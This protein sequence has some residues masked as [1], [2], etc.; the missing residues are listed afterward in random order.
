MRGKKG[1]ARPS[2]YFS[3]AQMTIRKDYNPFVPG[4]VKA[5]NK[6]T[7]SLNPRPL[8]CQC[9]SSPP[10]SVGRAHRNV[11]EKANVSVQ[12]SLPPY[13][14]PVPPVCP[15]CDNATSKQ[16]RRAPGASPSQPL[17]SNSGSSWGGCTWVTRRALEGECSQQV[18]VASHQGPAQGRGCRGQS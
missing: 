10:G 3:L 4:P 9:Y 14:S 2:N 5:S 8:S 15:C 7:S 6:K 11:P 16:P 1:E 18:L 13:V 12:L 17:V